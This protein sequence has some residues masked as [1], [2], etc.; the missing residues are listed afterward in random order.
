MTQSMKASADAELGLSY[1]GR[2]HASQLVHGDRLRQ[3]AAAFDRTEQGRVDHDAG[4][5]PVKGWRAARQVPP[6]SYRH[7][8][9][10]N[11]SLPTHILSRTRLSTRSTMTP[12]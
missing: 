10:I 11:N 8:P 1:G 5:H 9:R 3:D 2:V 12:D 7:Q 4:I 6:A